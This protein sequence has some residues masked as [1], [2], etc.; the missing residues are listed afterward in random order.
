MGLITPFSRRGNQGLGYHRKARA[1]G[2]VPPATPAPPLES[3]DL[4]TDLT[5]CFGNP[6][7]ASGMGQAGSHAPPATE[8]LGPGTVPK[9][10]LRVFHGSRTD[11]SKAGTA[12]RG[13][14]PIRPGAHRAIPLSL[15]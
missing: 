8:E 5:R 14:L 6:A 13:P 1:L 3:G 11:Q 4:S 2:V 9:G 15:A 7:R 10:L 12:P